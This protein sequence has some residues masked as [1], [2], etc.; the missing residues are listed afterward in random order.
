V[1]VSRRVFT[2]SPAVVTVIPVKIR[3]NTKVKDIK[4]WLRPSKGLQTRSEQ[5]LAASK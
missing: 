2:V 4:Q 3:I 1:N 5:R